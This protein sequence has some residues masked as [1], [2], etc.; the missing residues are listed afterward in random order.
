MQAG[1]SNWAGWVVRACCLTLALLALA[2]CGEGRQLDRL[3]A[4]ER[5]RVVEVRSGDVAVLD[6][7][8]VVRMVGL[9]APRL[10]E[11]GGD[12]ARTELQNLIGGQ[13][14][15]L[16]YGGARRDAYG[17]ALAQVRRTKDQRWIQGEMLRTGWARVWTFPDNRALA[18][19]MLGDEARARSA[20]RGLWAMPAYRVLLPGEVARDAHGF[21]IVEGR[22]ASV[23]EGRSGTYLDFTPD[24]R[25]FAVVIP[26]HDLTA[27]TAAGISPTLLAGRLIRVRG[28]I[29]WGGV[30]TVD[31]PEQIEQLREP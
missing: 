30:M 5:G 14:V 25:G 23:S 11:P 28:V 17:R 1:H 13:P 19:T 2:A 20:G 10:E 4:G 22:V 31:H 24:S 26:P 18:A 6:S 9:A 7:G 29:N 3:S 15:A 16:F 12:R 21:Q 8:L 27:L